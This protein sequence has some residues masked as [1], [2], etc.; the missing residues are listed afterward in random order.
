M[1]QRESKDLPMTHVYDAVEVLAGSFAETAF[2]MHAEEAIVGHEP[3][4]DT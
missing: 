1:R 2:A 4:F 3:S